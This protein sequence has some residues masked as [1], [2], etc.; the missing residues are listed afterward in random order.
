[1]KK[2]KVRTTI[3]IEDNLKTRIELLSI[4]NN[5]SFNKMLNYILELGYQFYLDRYEKYF[6]EQNIELKREEEIY[7]ES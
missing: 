7:E 2:V 4:K 1:M 6:E 5:T 3:R